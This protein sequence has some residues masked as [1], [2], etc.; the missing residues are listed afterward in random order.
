MVHTVQLTTRQAILILE[1]LEP[2]LNSES[3]KL[4]HA[5]TVE[6]HAV[7]QQIQH[8]LAYEGRLPAGSSELEPPIPTRR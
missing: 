6:L 5:D 1:Q 4:D 3:P 8:S 2:H 7:H